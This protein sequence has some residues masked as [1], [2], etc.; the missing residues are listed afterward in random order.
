MTQALAE[1][2]PIIFL[3][4]GAGATT[5]E[6]AG[7]LHSHGRMDAMLVV[8][9]NGEVVMLSTS[10]SSL[11]DIPRD[12]ATLED[13]SAW[14][15]LSQDG[16]ATHLTIG[17]TRLLTNITGQCP[18]CGVEV[19]GDHVWHE[20]APEYS[21]LEILPKSAWAVRSEEVDRAQGVTLLQADFDRLASIIAQAGGEADQALLV[22][23]RYYMNSDRLDYNWLY[24]GLGMNRLVSAIHG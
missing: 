10:A 14:V 9:Q 15:T 24:D 4:E 7:S 11:P 17:Q 22:V 1:G 18:Y 2:K 16:G 8:V 3:L 5:G 13:G 19:S 21:G 20:C 12:A 23:D 6:S